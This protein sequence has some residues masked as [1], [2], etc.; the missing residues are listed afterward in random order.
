MPEIGMKGKQEV[1]SRW[2]ALAGSGIAGAELVIRYDCIDER[3][4]IER[5]RRT[6]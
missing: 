6:G 4:M 2:P 1:I 5:C 3:R